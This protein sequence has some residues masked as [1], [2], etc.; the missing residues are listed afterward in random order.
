MQLSYLLLFYFNSYSLQSSDNAKSRAR[1]CDHDCACD[2]K[3][4]LGQELLISYENVFYNR[5]L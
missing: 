3:F 1:D 4:Q 5:S 2:R